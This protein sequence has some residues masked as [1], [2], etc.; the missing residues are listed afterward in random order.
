MNLLVDNIMSEAEPHTHQ[1]AQMGE[2]SAETLY[3]KGNE[4]S[5]PMNVI[6][7]L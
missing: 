5:Y 1:I 7:R 6:T 3:N 4:K 2:L